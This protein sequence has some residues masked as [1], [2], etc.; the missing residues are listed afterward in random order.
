MVLFGRVLC[1][2]QYSRLVAVFV[3]PAL[4]ILA[5]SMFYCFFGVCAYGGSASAVENSRI[6][7]LLKWVVGLPSLPVFTIQSVTSSRLVPE[8]AGFAV[9]AHVA[10]PHLPLK[11]AAFVGQLF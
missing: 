7:W 9:F 3:Q 8:G 2:E 11:T 1:F 10:T 6:C 4:I 5:G